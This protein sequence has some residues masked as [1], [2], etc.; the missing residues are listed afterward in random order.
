MYD[1]S[2]KSLDNQSLGTDNLFV[3]QVFNFN[4]T[5]LSLANR[6]MALLSSPELEYALKAIKEE[7]EEFETAHISQDYVGAVDAAIDLMYF[8]IGFLYRMGLTADQVSKCMTAVH[9]ANMEKKL[10]KTMT[11]RVEGVADATKP[12]GWVGPEER[13][14]EILGG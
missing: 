13:I 8:T 4:K 11:K 1:N 2:S 14:A 10:S 9:E 5:I 12:I 7:A 3:E 6:E